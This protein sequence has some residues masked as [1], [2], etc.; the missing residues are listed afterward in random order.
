MERGN[1]EWEDD[2]TTWSHDQL[3]AMWGTKRPNSELVAHMTRLYEE[4]KAK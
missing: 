1:L 4:N 3:E 2:K